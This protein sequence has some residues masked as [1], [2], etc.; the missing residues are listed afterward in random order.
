[1]LLPNTF[2]HGGNGGNGSYFSPPANRQ[3]GNGGGGGGGYGGG[4]GGAGYPP[5]PNQNDYFWAPDN[6]GNGGTCNIFNC[7]RI[8]GQGGGANGLGSDG[9]NSRRCAQGGGGNSGHGGNGLGGQGLIR[10]CGGGGGGGYGGGILTL[11]VRDITYVDDNP[12]CILVS[13]QQGGARGATLVNGEWPNQAANGQSGAGGLL[14]IT[15]ANFEPEDHIWNL[16]NGTY[17]EHNLNARNGGHG[18]ITGNPQR[19]Y[20]FGLPIISTADEALEFGGVI[21]N[22]NI[23]TDFSIENTGNEVLVISDI[24]VEGECFSVEFEEPLSIQSGEN[25]NLTI[26]FSPNNTGNFEGSLSISHNDPFQQVITIGMSGIGVAPVL[27]VDQELIDF[28]EVYLGGNSALELNVTNTGDANLIIND[29]STNNEFFAVQFENEIILEPESNRSILITFSP[30][31]IQE[32][33]GELHINSNAPFNG[34]MTIELSGAGISRELV[35]PLNQGWDLVSIN[36][37]PGDEFYDEEDNRGPDPI[38]MMEQFRID[39]DNHNLEMLK[40]EDGRFYS[41]E[42]NFNNISYWNILKGYQIKVREGAEGTWAGEVKPSDQEFWLDENW[43][44]VA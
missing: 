43:N 24:Q 10:A 13:G 7:E 11:V 27:T 38:L 31:D 26:A 2:G 18:I 44:M 25:Q 28:D 35:M 6:G 36:I 8:V 30:Q 22:E 34:E 20:V 39:E 12:P 1:V 23:T 21:A 16:G 15:R 41:P 5:G 14:H 4:Q 9:N 37:N 40:D 42:F 32:Y 17:G 33:F 29:I 3:L 19:V